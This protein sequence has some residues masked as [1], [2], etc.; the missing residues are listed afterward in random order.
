MV[1][2]KR[3]GRPSLR[4]EVPDLP[5]PSSISQSDANFDDPR[6]S[7]VRASKGDSGL[8][9]DIVEHLSMS[10]FKPPDPMPQK[11]PQ[12]TQKLYRPIIINPGPT[13]SAISEG[14][15]SLE[16]QRID[17][18]MSPLSPC[19]ETDTQNASPARSTISLQDSSITVSRA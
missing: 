2:R 11:L 15:K 16:E 14:K 19:T 12:S 7:N 6:S 18:P 17:D 8:S 1:P 13:P 9:E 3:R 4:T 5:A 10:V